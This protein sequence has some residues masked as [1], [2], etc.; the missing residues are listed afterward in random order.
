MDFVCSLCILALVLL[1]LVLGGGGCRERVVH[2]VV[3]D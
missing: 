2:E 3:V 1:A